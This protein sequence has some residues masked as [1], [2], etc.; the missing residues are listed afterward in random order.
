MRR[1][2]W[3]VV[4]VVWIALFFGG[5]VGCGGGST[6]PGVPTPGKLT[7]TPTGGSLDQGTT[8]Q[9]SV[10]AT[11]S[12]GTVVAG[13][14]VT[15]TSSNPSVLSFVPA[16]AGLACA[17][18]W[19]PQGQICSPQGVGIATVTAASNGV[20]SPPVTVYVHQRIDTIT[21]S[22][23]NPPTPQPDCLTPN[24]QPAVP[25]YLDFQARAFSQGVDITNTVGSFTFSLTNPTVVRQST[26]EPALNNNNGNQ[27]TRVRVTASTPG[28]TQLSADAAGVFS[29]P[30][31]VPDSK[32]ALHPYLE[33]CL[34]QSVNLQVG[35][36]QTSTS[37][38][39]A[40]GGSST[41]NA[42]VIDRLGN[43]LTNPPLTWT[44]LAPAN[45]TVSSGTVSAKAP[46]TT[47]IVA[48]CTP[49][50]C[51]IGLVG[52]EPI[53]PVHS[54]ISPLPG[55]Y[56]GTPITGL[57]TGAAV[58]SA[59]YVT[60]TQCETAAGV[61]VNGCQP[62]VYPIAT[63][64]N[65]VG[66]SVTLPSSPN[67][68]VFS[69][70]GTKAFLG[71]DAGLMLF[72]PGGTTATTQ[73]N[74]LPGKVLAISLDGNNIIVSDTK[75]TPNQ[76]SLVD[77]SGSAPLVTASLSING[78]TAAAFSPDA[79]KAF[80][81]GTLTNPGDTLY[82]YSTI[83]P[84]KVV[85]LS[86]SANG[87]APYANGSLV[88]L[89]GGDTAS[90]LTMRNS[91][92][93]VYGLADSVAIPRLPAIFQVLPD[94]V[95]AIGLDP[96]GVDIFSVKVLAPAPAA[97]GTPSTVT[98]PFTVTHPT[99]AFSFVNLGQGDF[100]PL[101]L[102]VAP[103]GSK[104][105]ILA[106]NLG[107]VFIYNFGVNTVS[108]IPLTGGPTPLDASLTSD[109]SVLYVGAADSSVHV[110]STVSGGDLQQITFINNNSTN[111][112]SL[113]SNLPQTCNPDLIAVQPK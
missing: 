106:S 84:M 32:G 29:Q 3:V 94:G 112:G 9:F 22:L 55:D 70:T 46:G 57:I 69:P 45:A 72:S 48:S 41:V 40:N 105:Y 30:A 23:F 87:V 43:Q 67:S 20:I 62:L 80:I 11:S 111:R 101:K 53:K 89:S 59:V 17:G 97:I 64:N 99:S 56:E 90:A 2:A 98:C 108:A 91:C 92:D 31:Q 8:L 44:S 24:P 18:R 10:S 77:V 54:S 113:C 1:L 78:S 75:S 6:A 39:I 93:S 38:T 52:L 74:T 63:N 7:L 34:V 102:I 37:F 66:P 16:A 58:T 49:P 68:F 73:I 71:S 83:E 85:A 21:V 88:Y 28:L 27:I 35:S 81:L 109:G 100:T 12:T 103:D 61:P 50:T 14:P 96:P 51:N 5:M 107:S 47:G 60:T 95:H 76:V 15:F 79:V 13:V 82:V 42:T 110:V 4:A 26:S 104:A 19:D 25:N 65:T 33:T 36:S 86:G